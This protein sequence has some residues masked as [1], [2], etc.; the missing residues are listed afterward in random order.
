MT[1]YTQETEAKMVLH[2][3]QLNEKSKRHYAAIEAV[4]LGYGGKRYIS[5]LFKLSEICIRKGLRELKNPELLSQIP[6]GKQR[7][8]GGGRKKKKLVIPK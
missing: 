3:S 2:F 8:K 4:K 1:K 7:R 6:D 5:K